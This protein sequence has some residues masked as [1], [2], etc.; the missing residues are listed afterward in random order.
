[1]DSS[2]PSLSKRHR[3]PSS[4]RFLLLVRYIRFL[5]A[6]RSKLIIHLFGGVVGRSDD[7]RIKGAARF[8]QSF[9]PI[10]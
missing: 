10:R 8:D 1:M 9:L 4:E 3:H 2:V 5:S 6:F 7:A